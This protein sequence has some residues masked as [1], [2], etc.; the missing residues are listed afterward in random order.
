MSKI[1]C[2]KCQHVLGDTDKS[3]DCYLNC[4]WC[5]KTIDVKVVMAKSTDYFRKEDND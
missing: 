1:L 4:R 5:K 2:P 3:I